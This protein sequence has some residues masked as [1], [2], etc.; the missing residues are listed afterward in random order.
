MVI[1][2]I[3]SKIENCN[4]LLKIVD[5]LKF[6]HYDKIE[7]SS[8]KNKF[9]NWNPQLRKKLIS[10]PK[11]KKGLITYLLNKGGVVDHFYR[12]LSDDE[13]LKYKHK[14]YKTVES[15][16]DRTKYQNIKNGLILFTGNG[17]KLR[18]TKLNN[19]DNNESIIRQIKNS[20]K[21]LIDNNY[22][23]EYKT[24]DYIID[25][26]LNK[27]NFNEIELNY[28]FNNVEL[29][30]LIKD[31]YGYLNEFEIAS[32]LSCVG[33]K[34]KDENKLSDSIKNYGEI[35]LHNTTCYLWGNS[36]SKCFLYNV[37]AKNEDRK[38]NL[39]GDLFKVELCLY[40]MFF[41]DKKIKLDFNFKNDIDYNKGLFKKVKDV[42]AMP[43]QN[44]K[45]HY[46]IIQNM[47]IRRRRATELSLEE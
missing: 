3:E 43:I 12:I 10:H 1:T 8:E 26:Y 41:K 6:T 46:L 32:H 15:L 16:F 21:Y 11:S 28:F 24:E 37:T 13:K 17:V 22:L 35:N 4:E 18:F 42:I 44:K 20:I 39:P 31:C 47:Y 45:T 9:E 7:I 2:D 27:F 30:N 38:Y 34:L 29:F 23:V 5:E 40:R 19:L 36:S 33:G 25:Y 14:G